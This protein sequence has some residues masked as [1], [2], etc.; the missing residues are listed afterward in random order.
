MKKWI[1]L[2]SVV[3]IFSGIGALA[4]NASDGTPTPTAS[5]T[6][7]A[8]TPSASPSVAA[9]Q[10]TAQ[11]RINNTVALNLLHHINRLEITQSQSAQSNLQTSSAQSY[12][13]SLITEHQA[14]EQQIQ[15]LATQENVTIF[16][17]Q[18]S[19][20]E[21]ALSAELSQTPAAEFDRAFLQAQIQGHDRALAN[22]QQMQAIVTDAEVKAAL[23]Q[24][25]SVIQEHRNQ[26]AAALASPG[27]TPTTQAQPTETPSVEP[28][29][30]PT[31]QATLLPI[32]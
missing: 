19:T 32:T 6:E 16:G 29:A 21:N 13:Q 9:A 17:F 1:S 12:A 5:P 7:E 26:A 18:P 20:Y 25:I 22:V 4:Q 28:S 3:V 14:N 31:T 10:P 24:A 2:F 11:E 30:S 15:T 8:A 27:A 23:T